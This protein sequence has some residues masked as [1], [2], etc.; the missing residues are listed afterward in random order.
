[1]RHRNAVLH[2]KCTEKHCREEPIALAVY[3]RMK[4]FHTL[5]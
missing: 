2:A 1:M 3:G 4:E 5:I